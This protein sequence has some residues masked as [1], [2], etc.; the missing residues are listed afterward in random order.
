MKKTRRIDVHHHILPPELVSKL[1]EV[2]V[3]DGLGVPLPEWSPEKSLSFMKKNKITTAIASTGIPVA[4]DYAWLRELARFCNEYT[5]ELKDEYPSTFGGFVTL[6][7]PDVN[8]ALIELKYALDTLK[9]DGVGFFT[10]YQGIYLGS[11]EFDEVFKELNKR[12]AVVF[13]HPI[14]PPEEYDSGLTM[15]N[16]LIEAPFETTRAVANLMY[17]GTTDRYPN[18]QYI[19]SHGGGVIPYLAW[20]IAL[21]RYKQENKRPPVMRALY[22]FYVRGGPE[23][24]L[25]I[26]KSMYYDTALTS[27]QYALRAL[28]EFV[29]PSKIVFGTDYPFAAHLAPTVT[30]DLVNYDGFSEQDLVCIEYQNSLK[31]F[32][33]L[34]R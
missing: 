22:D 7:L 34:E 23:T 9:L 11:K 13:I 5:A 10:H 26:L 12:K 16:A 6:P 8:G 2:G 3:E 28:Q 4:E 25:K 14:D 1:K 21:I 33:Q 27:S 24:G 18:I 20:R 31:L 15:P 30:K 29:G 17:T 32:P 19:L